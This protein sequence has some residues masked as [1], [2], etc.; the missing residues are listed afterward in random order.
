MPS[1]T[2]AQPIVLYRH[3]LSGH[4]HR[5]ELM[6]SLLDLPYETRDVDLLARAQKTP[7]FLAMNPFGTVP[8]IR[9]GEVTLADSNAILVYLVQ[10]YASNADAWWPRDAL[11]AAAVQRWLSIA[12]G[13][14]A[15][16]P[17]AARVIELFGLPT[18]PAPAMA[19]A[20]QLFGVM[21]TLLAATPFLAGGA[22][23]VADVALYSYTAHAPEGGVSLDAFAHVRAWLARVEALPRFR[24]MARSAIGLLRSAA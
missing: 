4:C 10:R 16:G 24:P 12:A 22:P 9:D 17:A 3:P 18:D 5:V 11:R 8:V 19:R 15:F 20:R 23:T 21:D 13:E 2:P 6:L 14:L 7:E 1:A